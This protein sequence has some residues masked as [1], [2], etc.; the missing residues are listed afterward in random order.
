M[1]NWQ[2]EEQP[3]QNQNQQN[4]SFVIKINYNGKTSSLKLSE[5]LTIEEII[6][7]FVNNS[8]NFILKVNGRECLLRK[9]LSYYEEEIKDNIIFYL[10]DKNDFKIENENENE[11]YNIEDTNDT[12]DDF[13]EEEEIDYDEIIIDKKIL[14]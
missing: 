1:G 13:E 8:Q 11:N 14:N 9:N 2:N 5:D 6:K 7:K 10:I 3:N 12:N 4:K